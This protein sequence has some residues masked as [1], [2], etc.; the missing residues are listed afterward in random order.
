MKKILKSIF[1]F[2]MKPYIR[3]K[4]LPALN[5]TFNYN[6]K[7]KILN[8]CFSFL[9]FVRHDGDYL[10]F[11]VW[12][13]GSLTAAYYLS[14][15]FKN[16]KNMKFYVFD[17]FE[18][19]PKKKGIDQLSGDFSEGD[20]ACSL[21]D[22]KNSLKKSRI[23]LKRVSFTKGWFSDTLNENTRKNLPIKKAALVYVDCDL[24][25]STVPV[26][27][28][29]TPYIIDGTIIL[30][31]DWF[32]FNGHPDRGEQLAFSEWLDKNTDIS[33]IPYKQFGWAGNSFILNKK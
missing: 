5:Q 23:D 16:L 15:K 19:L 29:I 2:L 17:S 3:Y 21:Q 12:K 4:I 1:V 33:A 6:R 24:Y 27:D 9:N 18:G 32:C 25:E 20:Y 7:E 10:E 31:D 30:F 26:L 8:Y 13:G 28:F 14:K 22:L 11:G